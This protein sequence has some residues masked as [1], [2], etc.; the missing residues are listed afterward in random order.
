MIFLKNRF[1][2]M[3]LMAKRKLVSFGFLKIRN[4]NCQIIKGFLK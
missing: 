1:I 2:Y 3:F 4:L